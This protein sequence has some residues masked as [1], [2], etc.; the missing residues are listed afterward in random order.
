M[1]HDLINTV[2]NVIS[3]L[4]GQ[5]MS[6]FAANNGD[7][8]DAGTIKGPPCEVFGMAKANHA[9]N[10]V[11]ATV[12]NVWEADDG[13]GTGAQ[14]ISGASISM[15][16]LNGVQTARFERT[17]R[18]LQARLASGGGTSTTAA[19]VVGFRGQLEKL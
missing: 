15:T 16:H 18:Y 3:Y 9:S 2:K 17:K 13:A 12:A 7:W 10:T 11:T 14:Q 4:K 5:D 19:I 6:A 1:F 8:V